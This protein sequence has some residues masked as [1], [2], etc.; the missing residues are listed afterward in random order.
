[1]RF[2]FLSVVLLCLFSFAPI[3]AQNVS[4]IEEIEAYRKEQN[5]E[6]LNP[7]KSPLTAQ[8]RKDFKGHDFFPIDEDYRVEARFEPTPDS[9]P[10][11]LNTSKGTT[12]L[13]KRIGI[14]HFELK[15]KPYTLEAYLQIQRFTIPGQK[16]YVFLPLI[17][18]TTGESTYDAGRY[19][20]YE[21]IPEGTD[22]VIDFNKLYNP[23]CAYSDKYECPMVPEPNHLPIAVEAGVKGY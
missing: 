6:F 1:M 18:A 7:S 16:T 21:G 11:P 3:N 17:D 23:Y 5:E 15:G 13:Y 20:H 12:Q 10:F 4:Y 14:L 9:K 19:L 22:W 8:E 2:L